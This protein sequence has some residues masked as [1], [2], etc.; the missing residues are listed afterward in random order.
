MVACRMT[1]GDTSQSGRRMFVWSLGLCMA[2]AI[3]TLVAPGPTV[4]FLKAATNAVFEYTTSFILLSVSGFLVLCL[5]L[6]ISPIGKWRLGPPDVKPDFSTVSWLSMLF[7]AGMGTGLVVWGVAEPM[8]HLL[9]P[10]VGEPGQDVPLAFLITH[11][12]WGLHAWAIYGIGA[13]ILAWFGFTQDTPYLP[14]SPIRSRFRGRWVKPVASGADLLAIFAVAFGVAGTM[15]MG[16]VQ[17]GSGLTA[18]AGF[19]ADS[20]L[21]DMGIMVVLVAAYMASAA[22]GLDKGIKILSNINMLLAIG[23]M[24]AMLW[25]GGVSNLLGAYVDN[26]VHY[27]SALPALS[28]DTQPF[29]GSDSWIRGWTLVY[30]IWWI[31]WTPFV[32]IFIA[33]ISRGR[34]IREFVLGVLIAPTLFS[35]FWFTV[36]GGVAVQLQSEGGFDYTAML[37]SDVTGV[38]YHV[39]E[40]ASGG[41]WAGVLTTFLLFIFMVTSVDSATFVLG[42]LTS[43]GTL[44]PARSR[45]IAWGVGLGLLGAAFAFVGS[46]ETIKVLTIAGAV[47]FLLV[48]LLQLWAFMG[49]LRSEYERRSS[50]SE[51]G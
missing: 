20:T 32:G 5:V 27:L 16:V 18:V 10:P 2:T 12:H 48:L 43:G 42:M 50:S 9:K 33:R 8:T 19:P 39:L 29:G 36:I 44:N 40:S 11:F 28:V 22:T 25:L 38:L 37:S 47:P 21:V 30:F 45:K 6:A 49:S 34:S 31:A 3:I 1:E 41:T 4:A 51:P 24:L 15:G 23:L 7:A 17:L 13:L 46:V 35:I 26:L 14:G